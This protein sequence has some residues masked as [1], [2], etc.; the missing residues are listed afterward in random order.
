[1]NCACKAYSFPHRPK[2]GRCFSTE[3]GPF[4]GHCGKPCE[5]RREDHGIGAYEYCGRTGIHSNIVSVSECCGDDVFE[6]ASL[7]IEYF[8]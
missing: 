6:D 7:T 3:R 5:T 1:M 2:S 4:C 8:D